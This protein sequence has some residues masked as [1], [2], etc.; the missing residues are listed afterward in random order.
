ML[1]L[2]RNYSGVCKK[3]KKDAQ[4]EKFKIQGASIGVDVR[5]V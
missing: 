2:V 4:F 3:E 1:Q 5:N